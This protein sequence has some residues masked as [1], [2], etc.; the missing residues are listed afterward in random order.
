[1]SLTDNTRPEDIRAMLAA[2]Q[3]TID[4]HEELLE[5]LTGCLSE[6]QPTFR[7]IM[8]AVCEYYDVSPV[9]IHANSRWL[10]EVYPRLIIYYL[11]R[12]LTRLS[13]KGIAQRVGR[14]DHATIYSGIQRI[15][16]RLRKDEVLRDD[17]DVLRMRIA[18]K[19]FQR[20]GGLRS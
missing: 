12:K 13:L 11:A 20:P 5:K 19:V 6:N 15:S 18:E 14:R 3:D 16:L 10:H 9:E 2:M 4:R 8:E 7:E 17:I 1:M